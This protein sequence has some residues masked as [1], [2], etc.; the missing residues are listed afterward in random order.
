M[1]SSKSSSSSPISGLIGAAPY[2]PVPNPGEGRIK[3][4]ALDIFFLLLWAATF[5]SSA[6][7]I[8]SRWSHSWLAPGGGED[9]GLSKVLEKGTEV[10]G[11]VKADDDCWVI[12]GAGEVVGFGKVVLLGR[13]WSLM[14]VGF[15]LFVL[16]VMGCRGKV[17]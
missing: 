1:E 2:D 8:S 7:P 14:G 12:A 10:E 17:C 15:P 6:Y 9:E 13:T 11:E 16:V 3:R 4:G 5:E